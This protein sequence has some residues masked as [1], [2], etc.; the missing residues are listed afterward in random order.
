MLQICW[1]KGRHKVSS[2]GSF[3]LLPVDALQL[4]ERRR[5]PFILQLS[6]DVLQMASYAFNS[7]TFH[8]LIQNV[9]KAKASASLCF[10]ACTQK[11][12]PPTPRI[13]QFGLHHQL[14]GPRLVYAFSFLHARGLPSPGDNPAGLSRQFL[15]SLAFFSF[16]EDMKGWYTR[17][18]DFPKVIVHFIKLLFKELVVW[19]NARLKVQRICFNLCSAKIL[20]GKPLCFSV[21]QF[22]SCIMGEAFFTSQGGHYEKIYIA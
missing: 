17:G 11:V 10:L 4:L 20:F 7:T 18:A 19:L 13:N 22:L 3:W 16:S 9:R 21:P 12:S 1:K 2:G 5:L 14:A 6:T 8:W 15:V